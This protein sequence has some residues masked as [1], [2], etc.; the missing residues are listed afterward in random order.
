MTERT[1]RTNVQLDAEER[2]L[3]RIQRE[4]WEM[5][6]LR[7]TFQQFQRLLGLGEDA[8]TSVLDRLIDSKFLRRDDDSR[9]ARLIG[10]SRPTQSTEGWPHRPKLTA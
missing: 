6:G 5:P 9:Y 1:V 8:C 10:G 4:Y 3:L 2:L 7:L